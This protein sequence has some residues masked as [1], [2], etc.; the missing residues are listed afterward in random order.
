M[1]SDSSYLT[2]WEVECTDQFVDWWATLSD[3]NA[4]R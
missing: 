4:R 2:T 3:G 1:M